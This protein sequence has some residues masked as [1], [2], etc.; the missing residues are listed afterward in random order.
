MYKAVIF[1][2]DGVVADTM[3]DN[4][5]AW[6]MALQTLG[7]EIETIEYYLL[8]GMGRFQIA[9]YFI[10]QYNLQPEL[11][12]KLAESKEYF[13]N[14]NSNF[15]LFP[16]ILEILKFI[17]QSNVKL[18][19]VTGASKN[20]INT[21]LN[22]EFLNLFDVIITADDVKD[23]KPN[24][25]PYEKAVRYLEIKASDVIVV[26]NAKLGIQSAKAAGC[27]C[28]AIETTLPSNYLMQANEIFSNHNNLFK[29]LKT[30]KFK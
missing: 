4:C 24:P 12:L 19:L 15:K 29:K 6:Q 5:K 9:N 21:Y 1:D 18:G 26:E 7:V 17:K 27:Y 25:E 2:F 10:K 14:Q 11:Y 30:L 8:E 23:S 13:Y 20:R 28:L 16:E 3:K 22:E